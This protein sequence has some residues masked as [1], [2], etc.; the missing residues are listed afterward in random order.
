M[1][2]LNAKS[3]I[4]ELEEIILIDNKKVNPLVSNFKNR[5]YI[6]PEQLKTINENRRKYSEMYLIRIRGDN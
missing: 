2:K 3:V 4:D 5:R 6:K 1:S